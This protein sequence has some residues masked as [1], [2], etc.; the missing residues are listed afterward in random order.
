MSLYHYLLALYTYSCAEY[1][2]YCVRNK[3]VLQNI[4]TNY[5]TKA[6]PNVDNTLYQCIF[7]AEQCG[8]VYVSLIHLIIHMQLE[9]FLFSLL[10]S[11]VSNEYIVDLWGAQCP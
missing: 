8:V 10:I 6:Q 4:F 9:S 2:I 7:K 3:Y 11:K 1:R 5:V